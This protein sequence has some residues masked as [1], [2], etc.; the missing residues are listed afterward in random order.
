MVHETTSAAST[1][2]QPPI[3]PCDSVSAQSTRSRRRYSLVDRD[4]FGMDTDDDFDE[5]QDQQPTRRRFNYNP[6]TDEEKQSAQQIPYGAEDRTYSWMFLPLIFAAIWNKPPP[7]SFILIPRWNDWVAAYRDDFAARG[8]GP[9]M[10][11]FEAAD[12]IPASVQEFLLIP[13]SIEPALPDPFN[14]AIPRTE[15]PTAIYADLAENA[16]RLH[17]SALLQ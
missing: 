12:Y 13:P 10:A 3:L 17:Q 6:D 5:D 2:T 8:C 15:V 16:F 14:C 11:A 7:P 4:S 9:V 1:I